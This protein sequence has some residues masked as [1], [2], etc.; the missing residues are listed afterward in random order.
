MAQL[1][2]LKPMDGLEALGGHVDL[3]HF[4]VYFL[5]GKVVSV[6]L[7]LLILRNP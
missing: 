2:A 1:E 7:L 5:E 6:V 3:G 4:C